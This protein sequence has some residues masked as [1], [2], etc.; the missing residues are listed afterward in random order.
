MNNAAAFYVPSYTNLNLVK[1]R[2]RGKVTFDNTDPGY[3]TDEEALNYIQDAES[4]IETRLNRQYVIPFVSSENLPFSEIT[5]RHT[6]Q[7]IQTLCTIMSAILIMP[8]YFGRSEG[9]RAN[10]YI[11]NEEKTLERKLKELT[12]W[13]PKSGSWL[14]IP[15]EDLK[16]NPKASFYSQ[17]AP[18]PHTVTLGIRAHD[19]GSRVIR[20]I[21]DPTRNIW[22]GNGWY[23]YPPY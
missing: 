13:D 21:T 9:V 22:G 8:V 17:G 4:E 6:I 5:S 23:G 15:M 11:D 20:R 14:S 18:A 2:L 10:D 19:L 3:V 7:R 12:E 16:Q 1:L